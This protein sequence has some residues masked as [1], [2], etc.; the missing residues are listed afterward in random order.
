MLTDDQK[1]T[2]VRQEVRNLIAFRQSHPRPSREAIRAEFDAFV[3]AY[4]TTVGGLNRDTEIAETGTTGHPQ[5]K[6]ASRRRPRGAHS[7]SRIQR[8]LVG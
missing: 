7:V 3:T 1:Q 2:I 4:A 6:E 5:Q 8:E